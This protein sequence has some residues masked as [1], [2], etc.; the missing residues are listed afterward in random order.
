MP[1]LVFLAVLIFAPF[2]NA[3]SYPTCS[4]IGVSG[5]TS[6]S[7]NNN[8]PVGT[9]CRDGSGPYVLWA[10][11]EWQHVSTPID[12]APPVFVDWAWAGNCGGGGQG[13]SIGIAYSEPYDN[14]P[15]PPSCSIKAGM[16]VAYD[17][18]LMDGW[19]HADE[20]DCHLICQYI[21][22]V[23]ETD[24]P[25]VCT[26]TGS[27]VTDPDP[28]DPDD[29]PFGNNPDPS[30]PDFC[31]VPG[32]YEGECL[33]ADH[34][35]NEGGCQS[36]YG[37]VDFGLGDVAIC[38]PSDGGANPGAI[39][40]SL[41]ADGDGIPN[42]D[43]PDMD[44]DGIP[45]SADDDI[46][47]DGVPNNSD[48]NPNGNQ[49]NGEGQ[50][51]TDANTGDGSSAGKA[52]TCANRPRSK[53]DAQLAAIHMQLWLNK[54]SG[55]SDKH[56]LKELQDMNEKLENLTEEVGDGEADSITEGAVSDGT[57][58]LDDFTD[59]HV[60]GIESEAEGGGPMA[61]IVEGSGLDGA[62]SDLVPSPGACTPMQ[63]QFAS[64][65]SVP[66]P[67]QRF[68]EF[69]AVFGWALYILTAYSIVMVAL[70][71]APKE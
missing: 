23:Y 56:L 57:D 26:Y 27:P 64:K 20:E 9:I 1:Y 60:A 54:C 46:D 62:F 34:P 41:D 61:G 3:Q 38:A 52:G 39:D 19:E 42:W 17:D 35:S 36:Q 12:D 16:A 13:Y 40:T 44:G 33:D 14:E 8:V 4:S 7:S 28:S 53:G 10:K 2:S 70:N 63:F 30:D 21:G 18:Y 51:G 49:G 69:K 15:P 59:D 24:D 5:G 67:C 48:G 32:E 58:G 47:G 37:T 31:N 6:C 29:A 25:I 43:D 71:S 68:E 65:L 66:I 45:N 22:V 50:D 11:F 55:N